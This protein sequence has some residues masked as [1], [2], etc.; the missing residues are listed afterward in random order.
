MFVVWGFIGFLLYNKISIFKKFVD[1]RSL[2][3]I[4]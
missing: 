3:E 4:I 2:H 1:T